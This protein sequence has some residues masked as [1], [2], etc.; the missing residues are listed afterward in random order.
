MKKTTFLAA[1][2]TLCSITL[3]SQQWVGFSNS[4]PT[5]PELNI[6]SSNTQTVSFEVT[7]VYNPDDK[8]GLRIFLRQPSN[9]AGKINGQMLGLQLSDTLNWQTQEEWVGKI[10]NLYWNEDSPKRLVAI[11]WTDS[12]LAGNLNCSQW[13]YLTNL[14]CSAN[15]LTLLDVSNC[16]NLTTLLCMENSLTALDVANCG[17][18]S[19]LFCYSNHLTS[20]DVSNSSE[21][22][23]LVCNNNMLRNLNIS[24]NTNL[25]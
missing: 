13:T 15:R 23:Q 7:E 10:E 24:S 1:V 3:K 9:A 6:L 11:G 2:V 17:K 25:T 18:L 22:V 12:H 21:L 20:L 14:D 8:E 16:L 19:N 4:E 5:A